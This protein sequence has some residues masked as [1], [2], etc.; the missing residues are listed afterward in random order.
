MSIQ[1]NGSVLSRSLARMDKEWELHK[2][3][4]ATMCL[5]THLPPVGTADIRIMIS[6]Y[7][8]AAI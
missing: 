2:Y 8:V 6:S 3:V 1:C 5:Q 4:F 7:A